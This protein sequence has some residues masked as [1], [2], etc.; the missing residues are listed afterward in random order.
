MSRDRSVNRTVGTSHCCPID[1]PDPRARNPLFGWDAAVEGR[2]TRGDQSLHQCAVTISYTTSL[3][4]GSRRV[5]VVAVILTSASP[6]VGSSPILRRLFSIFQAIGAPIHPS[7][8][9]LLLVTTPPLRK[10]RSTDS[11]LPFGLTNRRCVPSKLTEDQRKSL[12]ES[13]PH[14]LTLNTSKTTKTDRRMFRMLVL[15]WETRYGGFW[16]RAAG[17]P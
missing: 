6:S 11:F 5:S 13:M 1:R 12:V 3:P 15:N 2:G 10:L 17:R 14:A 8:L 16:P 4:D 7:L 9:Q